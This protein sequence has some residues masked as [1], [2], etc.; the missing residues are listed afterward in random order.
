VKNKIR[1]LWNGIRYGS[2]TGPQIVIDWDAGTVTMRNM[3]ER[4]AARLMSWIR[5]AP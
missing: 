3:P 2:P 1:R 4:L 5:A